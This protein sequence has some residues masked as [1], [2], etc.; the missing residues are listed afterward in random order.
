MYI[1]Y[2][3]GNINVGHPFNDTH[4]KEV[5]FASSFITLQIQMCCCKD[6]IITV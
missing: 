4:S 5:K 1:L 2:V 3:L 6:T